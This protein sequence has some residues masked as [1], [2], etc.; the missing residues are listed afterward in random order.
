MD[1]KNKNVFITGGAQ[2]IGF[3]IADLFM[4]HGANTA[5]FDL[6]GSALEKA[7]ATLQKKHAA[8][9]LPLQGDV[10]LAAEVTEAGEEAVQ[11]L[12]SLDVLVN[13]AGVAVLARTWE[14]TEEDWDKILRVNLKGTFLCTKAVLKQMLARSQGGAIVN[15]SSLNYAAATDGLAHY[16][17]AKAGVVQFTKVVAA[18][19]GPYG[20]RVNA[21]APGSI[22]TPLSEA[23]FLSGAM[24][25][26]FL[27][28]TPLGRIGEPEDVARVVVFLAS[29]YARWVTGH[30]IFADGGQHIR[31]LHS[32]WDTL[33]KMQ[34]NS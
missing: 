27:K 8:R 17:A 3:A 21:V 24:G 6:N 28:R 7:A 2:G 22:R 29:D 10:S 34:G 11:Q 25:Q 18:E 15:I 26:E 4:A 32:Y 13:N 33:Q 23:G 19:V 20:I 31:G 16:S 1:F 30:T 9:A 5:L 14:I 12:G